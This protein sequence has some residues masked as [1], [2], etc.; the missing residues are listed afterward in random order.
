[1]A[2]YYFYMGLIRVERH[3][4]RRVLERKAHVKK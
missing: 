1:M 2:M 3:P 4:T